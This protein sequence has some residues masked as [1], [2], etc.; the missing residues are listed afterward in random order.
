MEVP[1]VPAEEP[2]MDWALKLVAATLV[3][4][5]IHSPL[6]YA[7]GPAAACLRRVFSNADAGSTPATRLVKVVNRTGAKKLKEKYSVAHQNDVVE[8]FSTSNWR[9]RALALGFDERAFQDG[10]ID[11]DLGKLDS[12]IA[13]L[14]PTNRHRLLTNCSIPDGAGW[15]P[16]IGRGLRKLLDQN[17]FKNP[18]P[19][20]ALFHNKIRE[21][22]GAKPSPHRIF[23]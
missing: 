11:S 12:Y 4:F 8:G 17:G 6:A 14:A 20:A 10:V 2:A 22:I 15:K 13:L 23:A 1:E 7:H 16:P 5:Q 3:V 21:A 19:P 9:E 18:G